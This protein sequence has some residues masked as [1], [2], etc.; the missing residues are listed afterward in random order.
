MQRAVDTAS[1]AGSTAVLLVKARIAWLAARN[2]A[3]VAAPAVAVCA[4]AVIARRLMGR[5][6]DETATGAA[7]VPPAPAGAV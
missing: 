5:E 6:R 7:R 2:A 1:R 4:A 3:R